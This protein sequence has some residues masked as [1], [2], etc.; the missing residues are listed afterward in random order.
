MFWSPCQVQHRTRRLLCRHW[1]E[2]EGRN[3]VGKRKEG[4]SNQGGNSTE[5]VLVFC[6]LITFSGAGN[7]AEPHTGN[8]GL[9]EKLDD[10]FRM[11]IQLIKTLKNPIWLGA[12]RNLNTQLLELYISHILPYYPGMSLL[13]GQ[14]V[15][16]VPFM[17]TAED[18]NQCA[19]F[20]SFHTSVNPWPSKAMFT[21]VAVKTS[22]RS[23]FLLP[24]YKRTWRPPESIYI[25]VA[26]MLVVQ[27]FKIILAGGNHMPYKA[28]AVVVW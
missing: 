22:G 15:P 7:V 12:C 16:L 21:W 6:V 20:S 11:E 25:A 5:S 18:G 3:R 23:T 24:T 14:L 17:H 27:H 1:R 9:L 28:M 19:R 4:A 10:I 2:Q 26:K 8:S 13:Q